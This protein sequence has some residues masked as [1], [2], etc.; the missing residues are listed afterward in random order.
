MLLRGKCA[1]LRQSKLA[2]RA[3][4][5]SVMSHRRSSFYRKA[6]TDQTR[7]ALLIPTGH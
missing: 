4:A 5:L 6:L 1:L 2:R 7:D 3:T